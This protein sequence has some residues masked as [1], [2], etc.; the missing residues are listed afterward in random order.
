[1]RGLKDTSLIRSSPRALPSLASSL[2]GC[3]AVRYAI[4]S[5]PDESLNR[6]ERQNWRA[7]TESEAVVLTPAYW[8]QTL[9]KVETQEKLA[10]NVFRRVVLEPPT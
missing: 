7:P 10:A 9:E 2:S 5:A 3:H 4:D 8:K 6:F 1:M